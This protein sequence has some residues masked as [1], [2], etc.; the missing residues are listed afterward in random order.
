MTARM[1]APRTAG[2]ET[3]G[4]RCRGR[5]VGDRVAGLESRRGVRAIGIAAAIGALAGCD[6]VWGVDVHV[7][8]PGRAP[9]DDVTVAVAC[10]EGQYLSDRMAARTGPDGRIRIGGIGGAFPVGCDVYVAKPGWQTVRIR[11][12][13]LCPDGPDGCPRTFAFDLVLAPAGQ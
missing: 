5:H 2:V 13:D 7:Q 9:V 10:A 8:H 4:A 1:R 12:H 11:Y 6:P 3:A